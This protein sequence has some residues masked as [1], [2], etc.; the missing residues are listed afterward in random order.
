MN[1][2]TNAKILWVSTSYILVKISHED[3]L[4]GSAR[5]ALNSLMTEA[6]IEFIT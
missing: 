6:G 1:L 3:T 5:P 2:V 4:K